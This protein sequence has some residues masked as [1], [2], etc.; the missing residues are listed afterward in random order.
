VILSGNEMDF[1]HG[2]IRPWKTPVPFAECP[3]PEAFEY[4]SSYSYFDPPSLF[5][6]TMAETIPIEERTDKLLDV[7]CGTGIVGIYCLIKKMARLTTFVDVEPEGFIEARSNVIRAIERKSVL[8]SKVQFINPMSF[9]DLPAEVVRNHTV[10]AFNPPQLP[11][12]YVEDDYKRDVL[13]DR[14]LKSYR[15]GGEDGLDVARRFTQWFTRVAMEGQ[16]SVIVLSSFLGRQR[17]H[18][19]IGESGLY[20]NKIIETPT[21]LRAILSDAAGSFSR[22]EREDRCLS[23]DERDVWSKKL[24]TIVLEPR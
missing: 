8:E 13:N 22:T 11:L 4:V 1:T 18:E 21:L 14:V 3:W 5:T 20:I 10:I 19:M 23:K 16:R 6:K 7:G 17:I 12:R 2:T 15:S 9:E 24:F